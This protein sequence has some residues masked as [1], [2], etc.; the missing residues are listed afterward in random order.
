MES[1]KYYKL[2][3]DT[4]SIG[5]APQFIRIGKTLPK[6]KEEYFCS[7]IPGQNPGY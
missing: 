2:L 4:V 5:S 3:L 7:T 6:K 1:E